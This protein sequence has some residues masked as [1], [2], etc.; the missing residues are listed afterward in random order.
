[1]KKALEKTFRELASFDS[2]SKNESQVSAYIQDRLSSLGF[3]VRV[4]E[5]GNVIGSLSGK[6]KPILLNAHMD[7]VPPGK[8]HVPMKKGYILKSDGTTNLRADDIAGISIILE[9]VGTIVKEKR[10][11]FPLI[12]V[13][14]VQEEI[15]LWGAKALDVVDYG[16]THG[17]VYDNAF[18]SGT[19]VSK[20]AAYVAFDVE[21]K[22]KES[23][24]GKDL[25]QGVNALQVLLDTEI[26]LGNLDSGKSRLNVGIVTAGGARNVVPGSTI[27]KGELRSFLP[28]TKIAE[29]ID[30]LKSK[31]MRSADSLGASVEFTHDQLA[32]AYEI[33]VNEEL[34]QKY[35]DVVEKR[36][37]K[38]KTK[39]TFVASDANAL[40]GEKDL[41]VFVVSTGVKN[42][43]SIDET[44][45]LKDLE[46]L[47]KDL[48]VLLGSSVK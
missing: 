43:H 16:V 4:D 12:L 28:N 11:H 40:R 46:V 34:I 21:I 39:E 36:G 35:R 23:H 25:S 8:G 2:V 31:F 5:I 26:R 3:E 17:I 42:E 33:D 9:A 41:K 38:F 10:K 7:G 6:G 47:T 44:V 20:G 37:G 48:I 14:T 19:V 22:G 45:S 24:P 1:M 29:R 18:E 27:V 13:F 30:E 15:G 32:V